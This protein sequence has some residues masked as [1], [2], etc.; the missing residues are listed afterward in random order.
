MKFPPV[1]EPTILI[2]NRLVE[3]CETTRRFCQTARELD[4]DQSLESLLTRTAD[5]YER[6]VTELC[7]GLFQSAG[8]AAGDGTIEG[9]VSRVVEAVGQKTGQRDDPELLSALL[10]HEREVLDAFDEAM[11]QIEDDRLV[12]ILAAQRSVLA[13]LAKQAETASHAG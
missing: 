5:G 11:A 8:E 7:D 9:F 4:P 13:G 2:L 12:S 6:V 3:H 1:D 10:T